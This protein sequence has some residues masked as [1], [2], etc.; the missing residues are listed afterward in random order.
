MWDVFITIL[1]IALTNI[2]LHSFST[3]LFL[4]QLWKL[5]FVFS[6]KTLFLSFCVSRDKIAI[7][8]ML[9]FE[10]H[11]N[12]FCPIRKISK[13]LNTS[14]QN[15]TGSQLYSVC[16]R[17]C[18]CVCEVGGIDLFLIKSFG[19]AMWFVGLFVSLLFVYSTV[20]AFARWSCA[21]QPI[22]ESAGREKKE[23]A[24]VQ[25]VKKSRESKT[26]N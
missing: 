18:V 4:F 3:W 17:A 9:K 19:T 1:N 20:Y 11:S 15:T 21:D 10:L 22:L 7:F 2:K 5:M 14:C 16:V 12:H 24:R 6:W 13:Y 23:N 26:F 8:G 25:P